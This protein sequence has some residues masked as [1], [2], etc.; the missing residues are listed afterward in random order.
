MKF[1]IRTC[2][3]FENFTN[4][5]VVRSPRSGGTRSGCNPRER[6]GERSG[7]D[8]ATTWRG[9]ARAGLFCLLVVNITKFS[10]KTKRDEETFTPALAK[11]L[12]YAVLFV[13]NVLIFAVVRWEIYSFFGG[14]EKREGKSSFADLGFGAGLAV[15]KCAFSFALALVA[16]FRF[17]F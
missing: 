7:A 14:R 12:L 8:F 2:S 1:Q 3:R 4:Q 10:I 9:F 5:L 6:C 17:L 11:P 15:C 16:S 13:F